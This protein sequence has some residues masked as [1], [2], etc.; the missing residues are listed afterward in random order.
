MTQPNIYSNSAF[1]FVAFIVFGY[2][3]NLL[4]IF[5]MFSI[6]SVELSLNKS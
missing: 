4:W 5:K 3:V 6:F 2:F 1:I